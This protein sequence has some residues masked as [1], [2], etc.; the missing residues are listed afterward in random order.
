MAFDINSAFT[1]AQA[2]Q[3]QQ[4]EEQK[5]STFG[6]RFM[7]ALMG[8]AP[9]GQALLGAAFPGQ[10]EETPDGGASA[11]DTIR[12]A[13]TQTS[14]QVSPGT[15][16]EAAKQA[17]GEDIST[18]GIVAKA[19]G[20]GQMAN[21]MMA[22]LGMI[23]GGIKGYLKSKYVAPVGSQEGVTAAG[24][25]AI[26]RSVPTIPV[27]GAPDPGLPEEKPEE[28]GPEKLEAPSDERE[29]ALANIMGSLGLGGSRGGF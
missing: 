12:G 3:Q 4:E 10:R 13:I 26:A 8:G 18:G 6:Q 1:A 7:Q 2:L 24:R 9:A 21:P 25:A 15:E 27:A 23:G 5:S 14:P 19:K 17:R 20:A 29:K 16:S 28:A 22:V 11:G